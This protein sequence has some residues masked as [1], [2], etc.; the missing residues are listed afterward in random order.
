MCTSYDVYDF[1]HGLP[2][3]IKAFSV[4]AVTVGTVH[5]AGKRRG[6]RRT[7]LKDSSGSRSS[8]NRHRGDVAFVGAA[9]AA[10]DG[11]FGKAGSQ[12]GA[13]LRELFGMAGI[14]F[15]RQ[16]SVLYG[17]R[18]VPQEVKSNSRGIGAIRKADA[19]LAED[20]H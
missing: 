7:G 11:E 6:G 16:P 1:L 8:G 17:R 12:P 20:L 9:A 19:S 14:E 10:K 18:L 5:R 4:A 2:V 3:G 13:M 15:G